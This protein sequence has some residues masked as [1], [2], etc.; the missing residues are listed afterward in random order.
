MNIA[1]RKF[2]ALKSGPPVSKTTPTPWLLWNSARMTAKTNS[3]SSSNSTPVLLMIATTRTPKMFSSVMTTSVMIAIQLLVVEAVGR[4]VAEPDVVDDRDQR[5]RQRRNDRRHGQRARPQVDP[6]REPCV[7]LRVAEQLRPLEDGAG[8]REVRGHLREHESDDELAER[9]DR[10][11]P[12]ERPAERPDAEDEQRE[13]A[14][15]RRDVAERRGER[16]EEVEPAVQRLRVAEA[17]EIG[18]VVRRRGAGGGGHGGDASPLVTNVSRR[19]LPRRHA[20]DT[21]ALHGGA[22]VARPGSGLHAGA[23]ADGVRGDARAAR[24]GDPARPS[25]ARRALASRARPVRPARDLPLHPASGA[26]RPGPERAPARRPRP[27]RRDVRRRARAPECPAVARGARGLAR[28]LRQSPGDRARCRGARLPARRARRARA[29]GGARGRDA[30]AARGLPGLPP[31]RRAA[32]RRARGDH[33]QRSR[34]C[35]P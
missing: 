5:Q 34:S 8:D 30:G 12:D 35:P 20:T 33:G 17:G 31:R 15:G 3:P 22:A 19:G 2:E 14:G 25:R 29:A 28:G 4:H 6:A 26:H 27:P 11:R 9:D 23:L 24:H 1:T 32:P 7:R 21:F 13:D 18:A 10:E 16:A